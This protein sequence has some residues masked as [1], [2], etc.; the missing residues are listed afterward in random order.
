MTVAATRARIEAGV[1]AGLVSKVMEIAALRHGKRNW[2]ICGCTF[3]TMKR[4]HTENLN[5]GTPSRFTDSGH[6]WRAFSMG[7]YNERRERLR[8]ELTAEANR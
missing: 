5:C 3:C 8:A 7:R 1:A 2:Q 6:A 4:R